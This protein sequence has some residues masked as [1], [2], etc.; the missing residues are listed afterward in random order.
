MVLSNSKYNIIQINAAMTVVGFMLLHA[1]LGLF[2]GD[3]GR[4]VSYFYR[5]L[6]L[7]LSLYVL[8][9]LIKD[10]KIGKIPNFL[11]IYIV[12][13]TLYSLR[14]LYDKSFGP[15]VG[16]V[17]QESFT[18]NILTTIVCTFFPAYTIIV[19]RKYLDFNLIAKLLFWGGLI[20]LAGAL[21]EALRYGIVLQED[22]MEVGR[23]FGVLQ[24]AQ[25]S[26][27]VIIAAVHLFLNET[28]LKL[29]YIAGA[30]FSFLIVMATGARGGVVGMVVALG[31]YFVISSKKNKGLFV[32]AILA[33]VLFYV[34][35]VPILKSMESIFPIFST[36][37]LETVVEK[38]T[39]GRD[40]LY[41]EAQRLIFENPILGYSYRLNSDITGYTCHNGI[42][43][44]MLALGIPMGILFVIVYY[45]KGTIMSI[46][47][48][49]NKEL[50]FP[51]AIYIFSLVTSIS[52][53]SI[54]NATYCFSVGL[55]GSTYYIKLK[56][57]K[58]K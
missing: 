29:V 54:T 47:K 55:L 22:R 23:A 3:T 17:P 56:H 38:S 28:K 6:Q 24:I 39:G 21:I 30:I 12:I 1:V 37:M 32:F 27:V 2:L 16:A 18:E 58:R 50:M 57:N 43:D 45:I 48:M 8:V 41:E 9:I 36:R 11:S 19:S 5:G 33:L 49:V 13:M 40:P 26:G 10:A 14:M 34:N 4:T 7:I 15:F 53:S 52:G 20:S 51:A 44:I 31:V 46:K 35:L 42:L 25:M